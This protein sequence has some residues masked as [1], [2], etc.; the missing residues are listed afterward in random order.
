MGVHRFLT[1][2]FV[3]TCPLVAIGIDLYAIAHFTKS[4]EA[5]AESL[6]A[7]GL[8]IVLWLYFWGKRPRYGEGFGAA[9][10]IGVAALFIAT[11]AWLSNLPGRPESG[12]H[13]L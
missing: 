5:F 3:L 4:A 8:A 2:R 11:I 13:W 6:A 12:P 9:V 1:N 10:V 7:F